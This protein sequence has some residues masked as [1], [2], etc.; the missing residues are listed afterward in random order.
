MG[1]KK[2]RSLRKMERV[3]TRNG[4]KGKKKKEKEIPLKEKKRF[5]VTPPDLKNGK[6]FSEMKKMN[7]L[8]PFEVA[9]R[10]NMRISTAKNFL[11]KLEE[12]GAIQ[13]VSGNHNIKIYKIAT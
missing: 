12:S 1:G 8:T 3:Q 9:S 5:R 10:F 4:G 6:I 13:L 11:V 7:V 2:K